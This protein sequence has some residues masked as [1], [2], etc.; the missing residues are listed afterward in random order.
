MAYATAQYNIIDDK[1]NV[2]AVK[3]N[4]LTQSVFFF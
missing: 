2:K 4:D 1:I 3:I